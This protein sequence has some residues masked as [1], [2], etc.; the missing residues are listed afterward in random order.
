MAIHIQ[1]ILDLSHPL[2][3]RPEVDAID[4]GRLETKTAARYA[5]PTAPPS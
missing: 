4:S 3:T 2:V 1:R 5:A